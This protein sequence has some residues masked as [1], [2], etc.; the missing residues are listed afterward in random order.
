MLW[1][2]R[3]SPP[4]LQSAGLCSELAAGIS[5]RQGLRTPP[6]YSPC[7]PNSM[8]QIPATTHATLPRFGSLSGQSRGHTPPS[9]LAQNTLLPAW[10]SSPSRQRPEQQHQQQ[11]KLQQQQQQQQ[12]Q[13]QQQHGKQQQQ[14]KQLQQ[15]PS[16]TKAPVLLTR[17]V[18]APGSLQHTPLDSL[19]AAVATVRVVVAKQNGNGAIRLAQEVALNQVRRA[20]ESQLL[21]TACLCSV[22][23][24]LLE[25]L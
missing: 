5:P 11:D 10:S 3:S 6:K 20:K 15:A 12:A 17:Q 2:L 14:P 4:N 7:T 9:A 23:C 8:T 1:T 13:L 16:V 18:T 22:W 25:M 19:V 24:R 21:M